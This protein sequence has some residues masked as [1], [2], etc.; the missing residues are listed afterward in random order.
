MYSVILMT[1]M[2]AGAPET[3]QFFGLFRAPTTCWG[4]IGYTTCRGCS[5]CYGYSSCT[6]CWGGF[7]GWR[8]AWY[9]CC[10]VSC[11]GCGGVTVVPYMSPAAP[12]SSGLT[13]DVWGANYSYSDSRPFKAP[14]TPGIRFNNAPEK[15]QKKDNK[16]SGLDGSA[17]LI[18]EVPSDSK[19][20]IDGKQ[21][22][23]G[24]DVRHFK[25]PALES[26]QTYFY[27]VKVELEKDGKILTA[28]KR[29]YVRAGD[30]VQ[31]SLQPEIATANIAKK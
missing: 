26:G 30:V 11:Y 31:E 1:A 6:G 28:N 19:L 14:G 10:G 9:G 7:L 25:T 22:T 12:V 21:T 24:A 27:D 5:G 16:P 4:C 2:A 8:R 20:Y 29:V 15:E 3:P 18:I 17:R 13:R 23:S